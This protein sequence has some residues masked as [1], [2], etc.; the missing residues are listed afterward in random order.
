MIHPTVHIPE[1]GRLS[2]TSREAARLAI[3]D[4]TRD[5]LARGVRIQRLDIVARTAGQPDDKQRS[6][7]RGVAKAALVAKPRRSKA[8]EP[9][10]Y[11]ESIAN[12]K[13]KEG[14]P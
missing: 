4:A 12:L 11:A 2:V 6:R 7:L 1:N 10:W 8:S 14:R 9:A 3:K 5:F 13:A